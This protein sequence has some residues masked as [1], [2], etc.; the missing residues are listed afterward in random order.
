[1][2][3]RNKKGQFSKGNNSG[4]RFTREKLLG[5]QYAKGNAPNKTS[6]NKNTPMEQHPSWHGGIQK[7]K[8]DCIYINIKK[9]TRIRRPRKIYED[10]NGKMPAKHIIYHLDGNKYNDNIKNLIAISRAELLK[11]NAKR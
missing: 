11:L 5:N 7:I 2:I 1:M 10:A 8:N 6:F 4:Q 9:N 3:I